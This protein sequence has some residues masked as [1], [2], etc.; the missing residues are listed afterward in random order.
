M[1]SKV[2]LLIEMPLTALILRGNVAK[3]SPAT[4]PSHKGVSKLPFSSISISARYL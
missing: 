3:K 1:P 4:R 2:L